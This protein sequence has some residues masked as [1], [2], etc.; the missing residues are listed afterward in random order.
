MKDM[1]SPVMELFRRDAFV[2]DI[3]YGMRQV[4]RNPAFSAIAIAT[5]ALGIG[6]ITAMFSAFDTILHSTAPLCRRGPARH[7]LG[8][9]EQVRRRFDVLFNPR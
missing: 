2:R 8:R 7:G 1:M 5:L 9:H 4:R 6:G 3:R